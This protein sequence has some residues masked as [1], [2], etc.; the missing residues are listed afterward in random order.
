MDVRS[1]LQKVY[2]LH[3][4]MPTYI[5]YFMQVAFHIPI[6]VIAVIMP[7]IYVVQLEMST[8][9]VYSINAADV[10]DVEVRD[11][12]T[13]RQTKWLRPILISHAWLLIKRQKL[14]MVKSS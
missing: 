10:V 2:R 11:L 14:L 13:E 3:S 9:K 12:H 7:F 4:Q 8:L 1:N 5:Q 6:A